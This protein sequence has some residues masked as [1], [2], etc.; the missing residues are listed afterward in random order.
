MGTFLCY[1]V[2]FVWYKMEKSN[3]KI[4]LVVM[5]VFALLS[6]YIHY[7]ALVSV[8]CIYI[9]VDRYNYE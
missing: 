5:T 6:G 4:D 9:Y 7:F 2:L 8:I 1:N 3:K